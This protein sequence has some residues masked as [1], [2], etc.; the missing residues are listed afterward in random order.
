M[1]LGLQPKSHNACACLITGAAFF[2]PR[3]HRGRGG[4]RG[5]KPGLAWSP[6]GAAIAQASF[7]GEG[8]PRFLSRHSFLDQRRSLLKQLHW[9]RQ[10]QEE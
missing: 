9:C 8:S 1:K 6:P 5:G 3:K 7:P 10:G 2:R 4:G